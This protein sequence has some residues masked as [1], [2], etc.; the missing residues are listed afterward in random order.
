MLVVIKNEMT[1]H[2]L[3]PQ[4]GTQQGIKYTNYKLNMLNANTHKN[5][6]S[7]LDIYIN[8]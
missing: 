2:L 1:T 8:K 6:T 3:K 7:Y 5:E 4:N